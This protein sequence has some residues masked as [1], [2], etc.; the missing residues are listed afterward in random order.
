MRRS[1]V[2]SLSRYRL[3]YPVG[4]LE[5]AL[6]RETPV[7][8]GVASEQSVSCG[9]ENWRNFDAVEV[10]ELVE[11]RLRHGHALATGP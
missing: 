7:P 5:V 9:R 2:Q 11:A 8:L 10:S 4:G 6:V 1:I 3:E